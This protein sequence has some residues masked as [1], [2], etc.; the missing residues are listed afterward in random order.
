MKA[1]QRKLPGGNCGKHLDRLLAT[2]TC[3][4]SAH[5]VV[6][7]TNAVEALTKLGEDLWSLPSAKR[8]FFAF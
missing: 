7:I 2:S 8:G 1:E 5:W 3:L 6:T 4:A